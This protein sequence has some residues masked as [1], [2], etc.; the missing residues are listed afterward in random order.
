MAFVRLHEGRYAKRTRRDSGERV[1]AAGI[2]RRS[3]KAIMPGRPLR[4]AVA[5]CASVLVAAKIGAIDP[6]LLDFARAVS[7]DFNTRP[8]S[9]LFQ[10][11][12]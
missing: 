6:A 2:S 7:R 3:A 4:V 11:H 1:G 8:V 5:K 10:N 12:N 9:T